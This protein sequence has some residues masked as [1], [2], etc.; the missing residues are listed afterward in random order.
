M[1]GAVEEQRS[2]EAEISSFEDFFTQVFPRASRVAARIAG[3]NMAE[4]LALEALARAS[5]RWKA[6]SR[7]EYPQAWVI[8]VVTNAALDEVRRK[9]ALPPVKQMRDAPDDWA[10][11]EDLIGALRHLTRRQQEVVVLR[12]IADMSEGD[13]A[14]TLG[15]DAGTVKTH[16]HRAMPHLREHL[17]PSVQGERHDA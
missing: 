5:A 9:R 16:L 8:R 13:V 12:Y 11:R 1:M 10:Q 7:M 2:A 4:D 3:S 6:V 17:A 14:R 15:I